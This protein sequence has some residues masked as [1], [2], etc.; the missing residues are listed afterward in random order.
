MQI[1]PQCVTCLIAQMERAYRKFRP[2]ASAA[3]IVNFQ[4]K[5]MQK[6]SALETSASP[7][8]GQLAYTTLNESLGQVDPYRALKTH[9]NQIVEK[10]I[11]SLEKMI[12][13]ASN[14]V[15]M[16]I[17]LSILGNTIDFGTNHEIDLESDLARFSLDTLAIND[18]A[19]F[20]EILQNA[21]VVL[22]IGDNAGEIVL[23]RLMIK[24]LKSAYPEKKFIYAV[25]GGPVINDATI[26][27]A[28]EVKFHDLCEV[29]EGAACPGVILDQASR[30]FQ[31]AYLQGADLII[32]KGQGNFESLDDMNHSQA[33]I[34]FCLKLKCELVAQAFHKPLGSLVFCSRKHYLML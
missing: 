12:Q 10:F 18:Y 20:F 8:Y 23:D 2:N 31:Q 24:T 3:E 6:I 16:A 17:S 34:F 19:E 9:Y 33:P 28:D 14:P 22:I 4:K 13:N 5:V 15:L 32:S 11:P 29:V 26:E 27:D 30:G 21:K 25:R 1:Q 7:Y